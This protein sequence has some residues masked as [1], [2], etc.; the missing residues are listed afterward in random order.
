M[1]HANT[2]FRIFL[3]RHA[4]AGRD[5]QHIG[6]YDKNCSLTKEG[7][8]QATKLGKYLKNN[9]LT[10]EKIFTSTSPRSIQTCQI[11]LSEL[12]T[13]IK[14]KACSALDEISYGNWEGQNKN[15]IY[16]PETELKIRSKGHFFIPPEGESKRALERRV[17][18]WF[19]DEVL[20]NKS[21]LNKE[22]QI[23]IFSHGMAI[24]SFLAYVM[25][26]DRYLISRIT[27]EPTSVCILSFN[28]EGWFIDK[29]NDTSHLI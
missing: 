23:A 27:L 6:Y 2:S 24:K 16:I 20:N 19:E 17:S 13:S 7:K 11:V 12:G 25:N 4:D 14:P 9:N 3:I 8:I 21:Y 18:N 10:F 22:N 5:S 26:F 15:G 28:K 29:I 1:I